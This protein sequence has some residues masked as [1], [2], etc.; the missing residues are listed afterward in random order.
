MNELGI[1]ILCVLCVLLGGV[2]G[3]F[4]GAKF[5]RRRDSAPTPIDLS[6]DATNPVNGGVRRE[7]TVVSGGAVW[8]LR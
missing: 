1:G 8:Y 2:S 6:Y 3:A 4:L 5:A 7:K